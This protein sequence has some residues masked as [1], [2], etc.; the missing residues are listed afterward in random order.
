MIAKPALHNRENFWVCFFFIVS[1][2]LAL[3]I[4]GLILRQNATKITDALNQLLGTDSRFKDVRASRTTN[5]HVYLIG[6][7]SSIDD[8]SALHR[9]IEAAHLPAP[10]GFSVRV[11]SERPGNAG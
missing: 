10:P 6:R 9:L 1:L 2:G 5:G 7:V 11:E 3:A 8:L 4:Q